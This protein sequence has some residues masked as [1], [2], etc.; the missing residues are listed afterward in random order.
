MSVYDGL[1]LCRDT[2]GTLLDDQKR[3]SA[4]N[5]SAIGVFPGGGGRPASC[6]TPA[7]T[8]AR[9]PSQIA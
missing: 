5:L 9:P 3:V 7:I 8:R 4:E 6:S 1:F 2:D